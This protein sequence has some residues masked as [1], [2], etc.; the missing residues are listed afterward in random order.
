M[1]QKASKKLTAA[2]HAKHKI[3]IGAGLIIIAVLAALVL[4]LSII[5]KVT[6]DIRLNRINEIYSSIKLPDNTYFNQD[7]VF[8]DKRLYDYDESRSMASQK[9]FVVA[10]TVKETVALL[11]KSI[12][13][14]GYT[15]FE[16]AYPG[17]VSVQYHYKTDRGEYIRFT[18]SSKTRDDAFSNSFLMN[19]KYSDAD[20]KIDPNVGPSNV[21]LRVN[22]DDNNE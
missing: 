16:E 7:K 21:T 18:V 8:G 19:G 3:I 14:A 2:Q 4:S 1:V 22:L 11:D 5:P 12:K 15:F 20:F 9:D 6:S 13:D 17:S 10:K